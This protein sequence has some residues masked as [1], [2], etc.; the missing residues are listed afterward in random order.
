MNKIIIGVDVDD[1]VADFIPT[2][3][4]VIYE[5]CGERITLED[6]EPMWSIKPLLRPENQR[7]PEA[8]WNIPGLY[9]RVQP[10]PG[11]RQYVQELRRIPNSRVVFVTSF[12]GYTHMEAKLSWLMSWGFLPQDFNTARMD[13]YPAGDKSLLKLDFLLDDNV[14]NVETCHGVGLLVWKYHNSGTKLESGM[15]LP[16]RSGLKYAAQT[17][18][19]EIHRLRSAGVW[20]FR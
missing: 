12:P 8:A 13:Y 19:E 9:D 11:A 4:D 2:W 20:K 16:A 1:V 15:R 14:K 18:E 17:V 5:L 3:L 10:I 7:I 6:H